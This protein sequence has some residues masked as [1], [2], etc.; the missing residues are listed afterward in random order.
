[1]NEI[2][3]NDIELD[4]GFN[5]V[6][7]K[8][9]FTITKGEK[10]ALIGGNGCGKS[11]I[12]KVIMGL[13]SYDMGICTVRKGASL[14]YLNQEADLG[15]SGIVVHDFLQQA[16]AAIFAA[17]SKLRV[18]EAKMAEPN[19]NLDKLLSEYDRLQSEFITMGG[20][21]TEENFSK[22][23]SVFKLK[24]LLAK[25]CGELSGGQKTIVKLARVLLEE[26]DILLLDEPT[27]HLDIQALEW[28]EGFIREYR[29]TVITVSHDRYFVDKTAQK[30]ILM[31]RGQA[32]VFHGNYSFCIEEQERQTMLEFEQYKNRQK[33]IEAM[34]AAIKRFR[35]WGTMA[36]NPRLFKKAANMEKRIERM[37]LIEKPQADRKLPLHFQAGKRSGKRVLTIR[38]LCFDYGNTPIFADASMEVLFREHVC[39]MGANGTGKSTLIKL[40]LGELP[41]QS[42]ELSLAESA[43][44]GY[45]PQNVT[46]ED[47]TATILTAFQA[48]AKVHEGEARNILA[49]FYITRDNVHKRL[50]SLSGGERVILKL[51]MLMQTPVN[52]LILDEPTNHLDIDTKELLEESLADYQG[53][54]LFI[55][56]DRYF[57]NRLATRTYV[58]AAQSVAEI[59]FLRSGGVGE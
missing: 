55:S 17:E 21:E 44:T 54:L 3:L 43:K 11:T 25:K 51:A 45:I 14:G 2:I 31:Y 35:E 59:N 1:M 32:E 6:L 16:Q 39:L 50:H 23:I 37:E 15:E 33:Q 38:D 28:L 41:M 26:P 57:I 42:G 48:C 47:E 58:I 53:T 5:K 40:I 30:T 52:F 34:R 8:V 12:L 4:F 10:I 9:S 56:H 22:L 18:L 20:Y 13:Q 49:K 24:D 7:N 29:G 27:N 19:A 36:D 46:F